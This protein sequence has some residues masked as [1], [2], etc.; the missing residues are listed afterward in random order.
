MDL[1]AQPNKQQKEIEIMNNYI[2]VPLPEYRQEVIN[3]LNQILQSYKEWDGETEIKDIVTQG[4]TFSVSFCKSD[5]TEMSASEL[6]NIQDLF[7]SFGIVYE[8]NY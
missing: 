4:E 3:L 6:H 7:S 5:G 1:A 2:K 8:Y